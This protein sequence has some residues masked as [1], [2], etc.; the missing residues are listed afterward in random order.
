MTRYIPEYSTPEEIE[1]ELD[2]FKEI[3]FR[4]RNSIKIL[5]ERQYKI[6]TKRKKYNK[7]YNDSK[8]SKT[9]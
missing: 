1:N 4:I 9:I 5:Y 8:K 2:N 6:Q 3:D 7:E